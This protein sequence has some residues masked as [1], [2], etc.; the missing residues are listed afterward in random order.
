MP[1]F[2]GRENWL[3]HWRIRGYGRPIGIEENEQHIQQNTESVQRRDNALQDSPIERRISPMAESPFARQ[4]G[5]E[6]TRISNTTN[7]QY[8]IKRTNSHITQ[9]N[10][11]NIPI[12]SQTIASLIQRIKSNAERTLRQND[13]PAQAHPNYS[14]PKNDGP[15]GS[16]RNRETADAYN[17]LDESTTESHGPHTCA[18]QIKHAKHERNIINAIQ[19]VGATHSDARQ[20]QKRGE[21]NITDRS[22]EC[23][24]DKQSTADWK[25]DPD[26]SPVAGRRITHTVPIER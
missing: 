17:S 3:R 4:Q 22:N 6:D 14:Q 10:K 2:T 9:L 23:S 20:R 15:H 18:T 12:G 7:S 5:M 19:I 16:P 13:R 1:T 24:N 11:K 21:E 8:T 25:S 26:V